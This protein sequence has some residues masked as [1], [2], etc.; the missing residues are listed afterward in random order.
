MQQR[1]EDYNQETLLVV[2][3]LKDRVGNLGEFMD[4][5]Q[6]RQVPEPN[7]PSTS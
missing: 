3:V 2:T 6:S 5:Q 1:K 7:Q 4:L